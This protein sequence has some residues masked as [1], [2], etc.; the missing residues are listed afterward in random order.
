MGRAKKIG[1]ISL[2]VIALI[3]AL[4]FVG[5][6]RLLHLD[7]ARA[8]AQERAT[9][10]LGREVTISRAG[11]S[12]LPGPRV[13]FKDI[14][15]ADSAG[16]GSGPVIHMGSLDLVVGWKA[17]LQG[18][19]E[20]Q[21]LI[22]VDPRITFFRNSRGA[23]NGRETMLLLGGALL[24]GVGNGSGIDLGNDFPMPVSLS[25]K[26]VRIKDGEVVFR[27][28]SAE[29]LSR[30]LSVHGIDAAISCSDA[31][32][33]ITIT[34]S[35][36]PLGRHSRIDVNGTVGPV[37]E[38][39][40]PTRI[41]IDISL[42]TDNFR[43]EEVSL[44][45]KDIPLILSGTVRWEETIAGS[46]KGGF[47]FEQE[48]EFADVRIDS[49]RGFSIIRSLSG[50]LSQQGR[51]QPEVPSIQLE[52]LELTAGGARFSASGSVRHSG[53][54]P[55]VDLRFESGRI[56]LARLLKHF[57]DLARRI[58]AKGD[59]TI[60]GMA[61][62]TATKD[63]KASVDI[64]STYIEMDRGPLLME[65]ASD[66]D[67]EASLS[68]DHYEI[69]PPSLPMSVSAKLSVSEGRFE[70]VT[71]SDLTADLRIRNRWAS[72]DR[73]AF[74]AFGGRISGS[75]WFNMRDLPASYGNDV[76]IRDMEIDRFLTS[77]AG[78]KGIMYGKAS[79]DLF[80]SGRGRNMDQFK[81]TTTGL[82]QFR[83]ASGRY[84][85]ASF[86]RGALEAASLP[87]DG[88]LPDQTEFD[89]MD[90]TIAVRGGKIDFSGLT[91]SAA[92]WELAGSGII[93]L[94]Q[95]LSLRYFMT[96][97]DSVAS[98]IGED[99]VANLPRDNQGRLQIPFTLSG[100]FTSPEFSLD[101]D[102][103]RKSAG[104]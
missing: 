55:E 8:I 62:G 13:R 2:S 93:G 85:P 7:R 9:E 60:K 48:A 49:Q 96:L 72:L 84:T 44:P 61:K 80:V 1:L 100:T 50:S 16:F 66:S 10:V 15:I 29:V 70:W 73:M 89:S 24:S 52:R 11:L 83:I 34:A 76:E 3:L 25:F 69:L 38:R 35:I 18:R 22:L 41:P 26:D 95:G 63:L 98:R 40:D 74:S 57:P 12:L 45:L 14:S 79:L 104:N 82:G 88:S 27:D 97:S 5:V 103:V 37:G 32:A 51:I 94:D 47:L 102:A 92:D 43:L 4:F 36:K 81:E 65:K 91:C 39:P 30:D 77:F 6:P 99:R 31:G 19:V 58:V 53:V 86:L 90:S 64:T 20:V 56:D 87:V 21:R 46:V 28:Q 42:S 54:L 101:S 33:P 59:L 67:R 75:S 71:F 78:L 23:W 68:R 17:M